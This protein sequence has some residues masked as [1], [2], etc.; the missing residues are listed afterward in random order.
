MRRI[1]STAV[2][3]SCIA[4]VSALVPASALAAAAD[5]Y[6]K[7][8]GP[9]GPSKDGKHKSEIEVQ[10]FSWG[11]T[12]MGSAHVGGGMGTGKVNMQDLSVMRGP[13]QT[14]S[15]D[16]VQVAAGDVD[17]DGRADKAAPKPVSH[18]LRTH[19]VARTA[20]AG[21]GDG[22]GRGDTAAHVVK[23]P[24]DAA[25][26]QSSGKRTHPGMMKIEKPLS[27]GSITMNMK[28]AG[29]ATGTRYPSAE[30][31]TPGG[32]YALHDLVV[33][34]CGGGGG[35]GAGD[36]MAME[37]VTLSYSKIEVRGWDPKK[38]EQ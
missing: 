17:G 3:V 30:L 34:S 5:F 2:R 33:A 12:Q 37:Q 35:G 31:T 36:S 13:R 28:L 16:G 27:T 8:D 24:R 15:L 4:L 32:R 6:L 38:K 9:I 1:R 7:I 20:P 14:T 26:G 11:A 21:D 10:S 19:V 22:D 23:S 18:D 29:C 25:S